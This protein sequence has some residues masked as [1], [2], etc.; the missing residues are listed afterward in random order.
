MNA[1]SYH[2]E[3]NFKLSFR[4]PAEVRIPYKILESNYN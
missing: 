3:I 1:R 4:F 2:C